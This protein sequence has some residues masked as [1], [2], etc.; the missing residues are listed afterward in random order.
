[1]ME[2]GLTATGFSQGQAEGYLHRAGNSQI[3]RTHGRREVAF[4]NR[5][6]EDVLALERITAALNEQK[7]ET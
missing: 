2:L 6:W 1:M 7:A 5:A 4:L 3:T